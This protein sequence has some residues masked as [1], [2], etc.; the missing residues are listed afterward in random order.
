MV[1]L[2]FTKTPFDGDKR[3]ITPYLIFLNKEIDGVCEGVRVLDESIPTPEV[4]PHDKAMVEYDEQQEK[5]AFLRHLQAVKQC[6]QQNKIHLASVEANLQATAI[7]EYNAD[8]PQP[9]IPPIPVPPILPV[10]VHPGPFVYARNVAAAQRL[11]ATER[12]IEKVRKVSAA[13]LKRMED[14]LGYGIKT[15]HVKLLSDTTLHP[16]ERLV[17]MHAELKKLMESNHALISSIKND[18]RL[19]RQATDFRDLQEIIG[20]IDK[21]DFQI[22][23]MN[24]EQKYRESDLI[25]IV[26]GDKTHDPCFTA[27]KLDWTRRERN[28]NR[29][30]PPRSLTWDELKEEV[31]LH[32]DTLP[33]ASSTTALS[34]IALAAVAEKATCGHK[35]KNCRHKSWQYSQPAEQAKCRQIGSTITTNS[36]TH[37]TAG[38]HVKLHCHRDS[39]FAQVNRSVSGFPTRSQHGVVTRCQTHHSTTNNPANIP[40][41]HLNPTRRLAHLRTY[42]SM[43]LCEVT[44]GRHWRHASSDTGELPPNSDKDKAEE[45]QG[46]TQSQEKC[47]RKK[48]T[49]TMSNGQEQRL[50]T[51]MVKKTTLP[52]KSPSPR[53]LPR[54]PPPRTTPPRSE[55]PGD[56]H[57]DLPRPMVFPVKCIKCMQVKRIETR[58]QIL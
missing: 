57:R 31:N 11:T 54:R 43:S 12:A 21:F 46:H 22:A 18:V 49:N 50:S 17:R 15:K 36:Q 16:R 39:G 32:V 53:I 42:S 1:S 41:M 48:N 29:E 9:A 35:S 45:E 25:T 34:A 44:P 30:C 8:G 6:E 5:G 3:F 37:L 38:L 24:P 2:D 4:D 58:T 55:V 7:N 56:Y 23:S 47:Q 26:T 27:F 52:S 33:G 40:D 51:R 28:A 20:E 19:L 10:G 13:A 14:T